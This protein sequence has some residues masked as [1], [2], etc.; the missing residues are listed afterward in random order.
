MESCAQLQSC[1]TLCN[2]MDCS[3]PG[4]SV[5]RILQ[6]RILEWVAV[7]FSSGSS[8]PRD[9]TCVFYIDRQTL[10]HWATREVQYGAILITYFCKRHIS[11]LLCSVGHIDWLKYSLGREHTRIWISGGGESLGVNLEAGYHVR[12]ARACTHI[13]THSHTHIFNQ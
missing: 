4:S 12:D 9:Q 6:A 13:C 1:L 10:S 11:L 3:P 5:H 7:S 2:P 8:Q